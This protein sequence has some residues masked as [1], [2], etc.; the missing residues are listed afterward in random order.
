MSP[1]LLFFSFVLASVAGC[2][3]QACFQWTE[4]ERVT[5]TQVCPSRADAI[6][7]F[8]TCNSV[9]SVDSEGT[10]DA[11]NKLCCYDVTKNDNN[12]FGPCPGGE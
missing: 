9:R 4:Q 2:A 7:F 1:K 10:W 6:K 5:P 11:D 3:D 8:G 12:N